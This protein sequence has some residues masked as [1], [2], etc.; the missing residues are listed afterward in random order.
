MTIKRYLKDLKPE[1]MQTII[2]VLQRRGKRTRA[3][4]YEVMTKHR[5]FERA[6]AEL[7]KWI[8][9]ER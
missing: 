3:K 7:H 8:L 4:Y 1:E 9:T 6:Q 5:S 2:N